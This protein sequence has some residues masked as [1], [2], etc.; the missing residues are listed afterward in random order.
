MQFLP[1]S[2]P[3]S[4]LSSHRQQHLAMDKILFE[5]E[6]QACRAKTEDMSWL[7]ILNYSVRAAAM[8]DW[9]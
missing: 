1:K 4:G 5:K 9:N 8:R 6:L 7:E 2:T 3:K